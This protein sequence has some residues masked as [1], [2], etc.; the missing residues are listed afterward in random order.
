MDPETYP[1][2]KRILLSQ[3]NRTVVPTAVEGYLTVATLVLECEPS[4]KMQKRPIETVTQKLKKK[5]QKQ[6]HA[7]KR[8][9]HRIEFR[10]IISTLL[11]SKKISID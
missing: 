7:G 3:V 5:K 6:K 1:N 4:G 11:L 8:T 10:L 9:A 2:E